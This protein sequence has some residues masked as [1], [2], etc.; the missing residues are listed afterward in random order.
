[1]FA[2]RGACNVRNVR[3]QNY[4]DDVEVAS[5]Q[6]YICIYICI[7]VNYTIIIGIMQYRESV[8]VSRLRAT[9]HRFSIKYI[10]V[11]AWKE[12]TTV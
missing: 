3:I 4:A 1:M 7:I 2:F 9:F 11:C 12:E 10:K 6:S 5:E 8:R